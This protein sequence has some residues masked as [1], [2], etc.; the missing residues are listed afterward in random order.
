MEIKQPVAPYV[1]ITPAHNEEALI[2]NT[3]GSMIAQT[4][5]PLRWVVVNDDS[6]DDT[7]KIV[8]RYAASYDFIRL[9]NVRRSGDRHFGHKV[10]AFNRGLREVQGLNYQFIGNLD[11]DISL[12]NDYFE[13]VLHEFRRDSQ[14]G[15]A[16]G[17]VLSR[18]GEKFVSQDVALDS[19]AGAV[20]LF[21][22]DCFEQ[23]GG[24]LALPLGG[25]DS[26]AEITARMRGWRVRTFP[27]ISV[28][29][30]RRTGSSKSGPLGARVREGRRL[31]SLGYSLLFFCVRCIYRSMEHP[32]IVGSGAALFGYLQGMLG[33]DPIVLPL[34]VVNYL[35]NEQRKK[36][37]RKVVSS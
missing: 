31:Y 32:R 3:I 33:R 28:L 11:A 34:D 27:E 5:R 15:V 9:I 2:E 30:H 18:I 29:E 10:S 36:L 8:E 14:L 23:I 6:M 21:R 19:V 13:R 22:R 24:Y 12:G 20:Q 16:G 1:I 25:I 37:L 35:R 4:V 7:G 17:M 26:A